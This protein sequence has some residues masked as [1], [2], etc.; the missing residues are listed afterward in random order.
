MKSRPIP[1]LIVAILFIIVGLVG[2]LYHVKDFFQSSEK[3]YEILLEQLL[4]VLA[5]ASGIILLCAN[6]F[7]KWLSI[8]WILAHITI[9]AFHSIPET[10]AHIVFL[11]VVSILLFLPVSSTYL[12]KKKQ[13]IK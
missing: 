3:F 2:F 1:I 8:A 13:T 7:G 4:R 11:I 6:S 5:I 9:S 12:H 10:I